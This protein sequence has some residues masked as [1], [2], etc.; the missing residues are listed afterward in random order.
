MKK[1]AKIIL[2]LFV[3]ISVDVTAQQNILHKFTILDG[4]PNVTINDITQ[5]KIGYLWLATDS[6]LVAFDG[7]NFITSDIKNTS[8]VSAVLH[9]NNTLISA[10]DNKVFL[11]KNGKTIKLST[12]KVTKIIAL[13]DAIYLATT[14]GIFELKETILQPLAL[15]SKIDFSIINDIISYKNEV[16]IATNTGLWILDKIHNPTN[17]VKIL[18]D[19]FSTLLIVND[20]L[21]GAANNKNVKTIHRN[22]IKTIISTNEHIKTVKK[23]DNEL[24]L[25]TNNNGIEVY[26]VDDFSFK[27]KINKYN[28]AISNNITTVFKDSQ[29]YIWIGTKNDGL[30]KYKAL[31]FTNS[32]DK[33]PTIYI[34]NIAVNYANINNFSTKKL[35]LKPTEN[36]ISF[37][38]KTVDLQEPKQV[39]YRYKLMGDFSP[40]SSKNTIEFANL[41]AGSYTF[42]VQSKKGKVTSNLKHFSF[43]IEMPIY[44]KTWFYILCFSL[45]LFITSGLLD[46]YIKKINKRNQQKLDKLKFKNHLLGLEQKALQLQM[47]PHF[48]FN[49]L[50]GIKALG[51]A[52]KTR[53]LNTTISQFSILLRSILNNSRLEEISLHDE[54][55][56][57]KNYLDLEQKL[58]AKTFTYTIKTTLKNID[59]EE[60]LIPPMLLQPFIENSIK[61]G[62]SPNATDGKIEIDFEI[63]HQFIECIILDNGIGIHQS[64]KQKTTTNHTSVAFEVTKER[65]QNLSKYSAFSVEEIIKENTILGTK[66]WFKIPLK[67]D[68]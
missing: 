41:Q 7:I 66:I 44:K 9:K 1:V 11:H 13:K 19:N 59:A 65:I 52:G 29:N 43:V 15:H 60:I 17:I 31:N 54:I 36:N 49:V 5:D 39:E 3:L 46:L 23:L 27:Q 64:K 40:W 56:T 58:S 57:L 67:T 12:K 45:I 24:W 63:K 14:E 28:T 20:L 21:L 32:I 34:E 6:G 38:Y 8:K 2:L 26:N 42:I 53:E 35:T 62:I 25:I 51:N 50:N 22:N 47:N 61:H 18:D 16:Y 33:Q 37:T 68:F 48:I 4:L 55:E 30:Y 10:Y